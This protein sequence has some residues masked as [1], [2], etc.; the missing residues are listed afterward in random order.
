MNIHEAPPGPSGTNGEGEREYLV[1]MIKSLSTLARRS[2]EEELAILLEA[3][4][5]AA[6]V[7]K[8]ERR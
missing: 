1:S 6:R 2:R 5:A 3:I 4:V 7:S 8:R